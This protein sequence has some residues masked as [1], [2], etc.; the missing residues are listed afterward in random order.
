[1]GCFSE[2][3]GTSHGKWAD[4]RVRVKKDKKKVSNG[5]LTQ[6]R[7]AAA[8]TRQVGKTRDLVLSRG[9]GRD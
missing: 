8:L 6:R 9:C 2:S 5:T 4:K 3:W 1:M 7:A